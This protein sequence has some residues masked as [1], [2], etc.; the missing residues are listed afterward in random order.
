MRRTVCFTC[1]SVGAMAK[2]PE[3]ERKEAGGEGREDGVSLSKI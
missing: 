1:G 2:S 3:E